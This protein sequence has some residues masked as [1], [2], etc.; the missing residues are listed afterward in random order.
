MVQVGP[1]KAKKKKKKI[2]LASK[3]ITF[4]TPYSTEEG[5]RSRESKVLPRSHHNVASDRAATRTRSSS[6]G[7]NP[8]VKKKDSG[9]ALRVG[10]V[11]CRE[12][13]GL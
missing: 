6:E 5:T 1:S 12:R 10:K 4:P 8:G 11:D 2:A 13:R 3:F 7:V 9:N